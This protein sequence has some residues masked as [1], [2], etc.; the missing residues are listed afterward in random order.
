MLCFVWLAALGVP[1]INASSNNPHVAYTFNLNPDSVV[2]YK[3]M[4]LDLEN[5]N[6]SPQKDEVYEYYYMR[7]IYNT[8]NLFFRNYQK[9]IELIGG[10]KFQFTHEIY[11]RWIS[12]FDHNLHYLIIDKVKRFI[13]SGSFRAND[14]QN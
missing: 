7:N 8:E 12:E 9:T 4:L 2:E 13:E 14:T 1:V 10:Y 6:F 3:K 11:Q 5:L